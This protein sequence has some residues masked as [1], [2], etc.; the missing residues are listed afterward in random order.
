MRVILIILSIAALT[1]CKKN[2]FRISA[3]E[4]EPVSDKS[5]LRIG[6]FSSTV[7]NPAVQVKVNG[8]RM[9]GT[10]A[11]PT[12]FPGTSSDYLPLPPGKAD[13]SLTV[14]KV[15]TSEDSVPILSFSNSL[16]VNQKY[17]LFT[18]DT[19]PAISTILVKDD[20]KPSL[21]NAQVKFINLVPNAAAVDVYHRGVVVFSNVAFKS[22]TPYK[23][24]PAGSDSFYVRLAGTQ[25]L[26]DAKVVATTT[27]RVYTV[28]CR[29]Y[30]SATPA[31][32]AATV[33]SMV[34]D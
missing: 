9:S 2:T 22:V 31:A 30:R 5:F 28:F 20:G 23:E 21:T 1:A 27:R 6:Y 16:E 19:L 26:V 17:T 7:R 15:G 24:L 3:V 34:T 32:R 10:F 14:P 25:T 11:F 4:R 8:V 12:T 33:S 13:V 18:V 29:G